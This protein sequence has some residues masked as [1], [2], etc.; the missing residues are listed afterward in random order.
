MIPPHP[1][2]DREEEMQAEI[3]RLRAALQWYAEAS[4]LRRDQDRGKLA[5]EVLNEQ[6]ASDTERYQNT[7]KT[8]ME[9]GKS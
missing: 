1:I 6:S 3:E 9:A 5:R 4:P 7:I 2:T 8:I